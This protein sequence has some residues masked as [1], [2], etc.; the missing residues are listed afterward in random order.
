MQTT[1][2]ETSAA[3]TQGNAHVEP[4]MFSKRIGSTTYVVAVHFS[5]TAIETMQDKFKRLIES[6]VRHSA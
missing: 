5:Q 1:V 2:T 4:T 3:R 6:E